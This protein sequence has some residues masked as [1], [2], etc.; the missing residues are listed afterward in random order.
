MVI[1]AVTGCGSLS[2]KSSLWVIFILL[3]TAFGS[4]LIIVFSNSDYFINTFTAKI[5]F[6]KF[7]TGFNIA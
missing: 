5:R 6:L 4:I 1:T 2:Q 3:I 7:F